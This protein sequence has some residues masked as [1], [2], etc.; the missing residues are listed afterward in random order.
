MKEFERTET[1]LEN[2]AADAQK[3]YDIEQIKVLIH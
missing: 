2:K 3:R 1:D